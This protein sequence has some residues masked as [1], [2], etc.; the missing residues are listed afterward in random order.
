MFT[1]WIFSFLVSLRLH[2]ERKKLIPTFAC[3]PAEKIIL[4]SQQVKTDVHR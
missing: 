3:L 2:S 1:T 4:I